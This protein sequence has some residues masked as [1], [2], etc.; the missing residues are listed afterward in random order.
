MLEKF[1]KPH[2]AYKT[3]TLVLSVKYSGSKLPSW[4]Y[5]T[6]SLVANLRPK[7]SAAEAASTHGMPISHAIG[8]K[9][10]PNIFCSDRSDII[11]LKKP[12]TIE[13]K[14]NIAIKIAATLTAI[15]R[16]SFVPFVIASIEP[17]YMFSSLA[18]LI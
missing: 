13:T 15:F 10:Q 5:A 2:K 14:A 8:A 11:K 7:S 9:I 17:A 18:S 6:N 16:P 12:S 4:M 3:I 1:A